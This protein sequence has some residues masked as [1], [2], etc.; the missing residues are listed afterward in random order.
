MEEVRLF[1]SVAIDY[2]TES[3]PPE[4]NN[5]LSSLDSVDVHR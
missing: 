5:I 1:S 2:E 3:I 4:K